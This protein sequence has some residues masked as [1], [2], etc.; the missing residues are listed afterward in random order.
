MDAPDAPKHEFL[1]GLPVRVEAWIRKYVTR[2]KIAG[3]L[4][5]LLVFILAA[6]AE[7]E[8]N[9]LWTERLRPWFV[10]PYPEWHVSNGLITFIIFNGIATFVFFVLSVLIY[11]ADRRRLGQL[12]NLRQENTH[13]RHQLSTLTTTLYEQT[14]QLDKCCADRDDFEQELEVR[15]KEANLLDLFSNIDSELY[16][17]LL[18]GKPGEEEVHNFVSSVLRRICA[19]F[20]NNI[21]RTSVYTPD[22]NDP[23]FLTIRWDSGV[24]EVSRWANRW[25][26]G[27]TDPT[28]NHKRRGIPGA[29]WLKREGRVNAHVRED[30]DF[31]DPHQPP[32]DF[33]PYESTLHALIH[34]S[35]EQ[36][37]LGILALDSK[38][39]TFTD[40]DLQLV[41]QAATRIGW[42]MICL[43][44]AAR[45]S[46]EKDRS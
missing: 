40:H 5:A 41:T 25:Y 32:R 17:L 43:D 46:A 33:L 2:W 45:S 38:D 12:E 14:R 13:H 10:A 20:G 18:Q 21:V 7:G 11:G 8:I 24:G 3:L 39:Y 23:E 27:G 42:F 31:V 16:L 15:R 26:I 37:G 6:I 36:K 19:L 22:P 34:P 1:K 9:R 4:V 30:P 29:V 35:D 28:I 44:N